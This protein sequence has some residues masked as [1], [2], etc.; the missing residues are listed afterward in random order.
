MDSTKYFVPLKIL[1]ITENGDIF[2]YT[3]EILDNEK[4]IT[5]IVKNADEALGKIKKEQFEIIVMEVKT[6]GV[7][8][9]E[10]VKYVKESQSENCL[11]ITAGYSSIQDALKTLK[12]GAYDFIS[13]P[14]DEDTTKIILNKVV[15][16]QSLYKERNHF[17]E[18]ST[19]DSLTEV[20][21]R[22]Y[23][24][25]LISNEFSR[26]MRFK[27]DLSL[28]LVDIDNFKYF[29]DAYGHLIGDKILKGFVKILLESVRKI[30]Y[31]CRFG[32]DEFIIVL[33]ETG[34][35]GA[36]N[37]ARRLQSSILKTVIHIDNKVEAKLAI[38]IGISTYPHDAS[39][40]EQL[41]EKADHAL[42]DV[43]K[44]GKGQIGFFADDGNVLIPKK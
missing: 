29:N 20:F 23:F 24:Q 5:T 26:S 16:R 7:D 41:V 32:G 6:P 43:K 18:L 34:K 13:K 35:E 8:D 11:I 27:H 22:R 44:M 19:I 31:V 12:A 10:V 2:K 1:I 28:I 30:D 21:N 14:F 15:E 3:R 40:N 36:Y 33:P 9:F 38:S 4:F 37:L 42:Y 17:R 39:N 25:E